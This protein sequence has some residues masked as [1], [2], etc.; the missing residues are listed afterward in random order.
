MPTRVVQFLVKALDK[1]EDEYWFDV[2]IDL[3]PADKAASFSRMLELY[4]RIG[5]PLRRHTLVWPNTYGEKHGLT[6][7]ELKEIEDE[8]MKL[9][10]HEAYAHRP[11]VV[12][13]RYTVR[14]D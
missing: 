3:L 12:I 8:L 13:K 11:F 4:D 14:F 5:K 1:A 2:F 10:D 9:E 7:A 6:K